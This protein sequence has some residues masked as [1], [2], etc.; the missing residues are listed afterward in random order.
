MIWS[1]TVCFH[2]AAR[3]FWILWHAEFA[4]ETYHDFLNY[5]GS[6]LRFFWNYKGI[7]LP[8]Y[9]SCSDIFGIH[10]LPLLIWE[11][12]LV[13]LSKLRCFLYRFI[14][15]EKFL[16]IFCPYRGKVYCLLLYVANK[17]CWYLLFFLSVI[18]FILF[19]RVE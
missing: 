12:L 19:V 5:Q 6:V 3:F 11:F 16:Y 14:V 13:F 9:K 1:W 8:S 17:T 2:F 4:Y 7:K 10:S 15:I 18:F